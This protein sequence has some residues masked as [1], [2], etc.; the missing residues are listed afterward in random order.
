MTCVARL[1]QEKNQ[2]GLIRAF[3]KL[4]SI[5]EK[6]VHLCLI[7]SGSDLPKLESMVRELNLGPRVHFLGSQSN[8]YPF[9]AASDLFVLLSSPPEAGGVESLSNALLE[10]MSCGVPVIVSRNGSEEVVTDGVDGFIVNWDDTLAIVDRMYAM[11]HNDDARK[12]F[13][14]KARQKIT[15]QYTIDQTIKSNLSLYEELPRRSNSIRRITSLNKLIVRKM[16]S[17]RV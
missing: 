4:A 7:G 17:G 12:A 3:A 16:I 9:L 15:Q 8:V 10:A 13:G 11:I 6:D 14:E 1:E 2:I 5:T